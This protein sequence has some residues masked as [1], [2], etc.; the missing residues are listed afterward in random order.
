MEAP[1]ALPYAEAQVQARNDLLC[2][3][4]DVLIASLEDQIL[5]DAKFEIFS[6]RLQYLIETG[7]GA[8]SNSPG[9]EN[10]P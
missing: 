2:N 8:V 4:R 5:R 1:L 7:F 3:H 9:G 6:D 10:L